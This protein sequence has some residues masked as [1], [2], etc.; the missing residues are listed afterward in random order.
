MI[1]RDDN[2]PAFEE[3]LAELDRARSIAAFAILTME[4]VA[5]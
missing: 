1:Q 5:A 4:E 3:L 2:F